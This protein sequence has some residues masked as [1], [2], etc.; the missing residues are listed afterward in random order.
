MQENCSKNIQSNP[1]VRV[2]NKIIQTSSVFKPEPDWASIEIE[3]QQ[4][5]GHFL[6][7][8]RNWILFK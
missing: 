7:F 8:E 5:P 4:R 6:I 3:T 1:W 2:Q